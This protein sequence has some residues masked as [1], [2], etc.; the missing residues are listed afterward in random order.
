MLII[1]GNKYY[2][3]NNDRNLVK[4]DVKEDINCNVFL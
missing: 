4:N 2:T 1:P 3:L